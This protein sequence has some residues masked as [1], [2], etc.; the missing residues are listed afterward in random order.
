MQNTMLKSIAKYC[1][2]VSTGEDVDM[3]ILAPYIQS[4]MKEDW[5]ETRSEW[6]YFITQTTFQPFF[7]E[8]VK[9]STKNK[10]T[11]VLIDELSE[12]H[13]RKNHDL[14]NSNSYFFNE[15]TPY[16]LLSFVFDLKVFEGFQGL[17]Q[18][19]LYSDIKYEIHTKKVRHWIENGCLQTHTMGIKN[20]N[21]KFDDFILNDLLNPRYQEK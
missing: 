11:Q 6:N 15:Y 9:D 20:S 2:M 5:K 19:E 3:A 14:F 7:R 10:V 8:T 4:D 21:N 18:R 17:D 13:G 1:E 12:F 16:D